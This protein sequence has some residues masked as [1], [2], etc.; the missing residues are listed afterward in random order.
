MAGFLLLFV[1]NGVIVFIKIRRKKM[2]KFNT[3][4]SYVT[5]AKKI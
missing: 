2:M 1:R 4:R 3:F 5:K